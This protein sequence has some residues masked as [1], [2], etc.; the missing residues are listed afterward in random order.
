M[1]EKKVNGSEG[2]TI[3][4]D[5]RNKNTDKLWILDSDWTESFD[6]YIYVKH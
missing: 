6:L 3:Y 4:S 5:N 2:M 1:T